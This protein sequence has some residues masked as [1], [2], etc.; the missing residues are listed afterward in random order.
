MIAST[1]HELLERAMWDLFWIPDDVTVIDRADLLLLRCERPVQLLNT[2]LRGIATPDRID[3]LVDETRDLH[4]HTSSRWWIPDIRPSIHVEAALSRA[5][6]SA[7]M[8]H[9][10][11]GI[12][13][14]AFQSRPRSEFSVLAVDSVERMRHCVHVGNEA[15]GRT[16]A[17]SDDELAR[18]LALCN[19]PGARVHRFVAYDR[20]DVPVASASM[21]SFADLRFGFLWGG[22]TIPA[23]RGRGA[24]FALLATRLAHA[25]ALGLSLA[26]LYARTSTSAP[27]VTR[28]GF[29]RWGEMTYWDR[30]C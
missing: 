11:R 1:P 24:Y 7:G 20:S 4:A 27:I 30:P 22:G 23:A 5:G 13:V 14:A 15:F 12:D 8:R 26:G 16:D 19:G 2:V 9:E 18:D 10:A 6:Y 21:T 29:E 25:R 17:V 3:A 28:C